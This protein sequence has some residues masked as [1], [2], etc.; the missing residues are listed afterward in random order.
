MRYMEDPGQSELF[1][2]FESI[3]SPVAFRKLSSGWQHLFRCAILKLMP[4]KKLAEHFHPD[5]GRPTKELYSM[6]ALL[7]VMEFRDWTHE[8]A[9]D[10]Y[11]FNADLQYALNLRP[12]NQSLCRRT[13]ERYITLF[14][15]DELAQNIMIDVTAEL[16]GLLDLDVSKQRLD[17]TYIH[18]NMAKFGRIKL[19][20]TAI[21]R[22]LTQVLRHD[23]GS[24]KRLPKALRER[25]EASSNAVFGWKKLDD[26][27]VSELR[28]SV[29]EDLCFLVESYRRNKKHNGRSTYTMLV[30][31]FEQQCD[32]VD[33]KVAVKKKTGGD[34]IVNPSDPDATFSG[35]K[36]SGYQAQIAETCS[37]E[38]DVQLVTVALVETAADPDSKAIPK[39]LDHYEDHGHRPDTLYAD[40]AYGSDDNYEK[41][42][43]GRSYET[44][45]D[46]RGMH[47][48][49]RDEAV[50]R[51]VSPTSGTKK[52]KC[53][54]STD[55]QSA[56]AQPLTILDF[57][58]ST[59]EN[60]FTK[61]PAGRE[62]HRT[63]NNDDKHH[64]MMLGETCKGCPLRARCPMRPDP[65]LPDLRITGKE[66]R[67]ARRRQSETT[68]AFRDA[69]RIR[70][71]IEATN[72]GI[73]R[74]TGMSRPPG[75]Q[76]P[77]GYDERIAEACRLERSSRQ[78]DR[79]HGC[80]HCQN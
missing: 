62:L 32:V 37:E 2:F 73:K 33:D 75:S 51:L 48:G 16:V 26:D 3:L 57:E 68:Q 7:F 35:H 1:D 25:Y 45:D 14:R 11:M 8:E 60:R 70:G 6:A 19:M 15:E 41:C 17:S 21:R 74:V 34:I 47:E 76:S 40:T 54:P 43:R 59:T 20:S 78:H 23:E 39:A 18:S 49:K 77:G 55:E 42:Y 28:Q 69:Y 65:Y 53:E 71:G 4:A 79:A 31:V 80:E 13:I 24:Y 58:F 5:M 29:A 52:I 30:K 64:I 27:G 46:Y 56:E 66:L 22:F 38:N 63:H 67:L 72:S 61:C 44:F 50:I 9:A 12:E 10:A 36:G